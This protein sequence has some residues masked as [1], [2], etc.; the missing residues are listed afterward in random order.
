[1]GRSEP[2]V[3]WLIVHNPLPEE[4]VDVY[5]NVQLMYS[6]CRCVLVQHTPTMANFKLLHL[7]EHPQSTMGEPCGEAHPRTAA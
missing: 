3:C 1:M 6:I 4:D 5:A 2:V 7:I